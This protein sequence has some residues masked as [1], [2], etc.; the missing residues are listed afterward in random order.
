ML[1]EMFCVDC[2]Y[3]VKMNVCLLMYNFACLIQK[4]YIGRMGVVLSAM[5]LYVK[6]KENKKRIP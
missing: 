4:R 1:C 5:K 2:E 3:E 6:W